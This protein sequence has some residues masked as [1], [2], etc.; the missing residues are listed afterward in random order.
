MGKYS[1]PGKHIGTKEI[2]NKPGNNFDRHRTA[3]ATNNQRLAVGA[4]CLP[5]KAMV[6]PFLCSL[7][8]ENSEI[9]IAIGTS[10]HVMS[11]DD[12]VQS[13]LSALFGAQLLRT[14]DLYLQVSSESAMLWSL[15]PP[16]ID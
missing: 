9:Q 11:T 15:H 12:F 13:L 1:T 16:T 2:V 4:T 14:S 3:T 5:T 7:M 8:I 10:S 6:L